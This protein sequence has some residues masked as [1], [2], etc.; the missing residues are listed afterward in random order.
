[1]VKTW[2]EEPHTYLQFK[3]I[4]VQKHQTVGGVINKLIRR[5]VAENQ[6]KE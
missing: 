6:V 2:Q 5:Y 4:C 1:M 3:M